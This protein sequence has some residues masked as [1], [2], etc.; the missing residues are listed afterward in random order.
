MNRNN[1][2]IFDQY[3]DDFQFEPYEDDEPSSVKR[4]KDHDLLFHLSTQAMKHNVLINELSKDSSSLDS[5]LVSLNLANA[6]ISRRIQRLEQTVSTGTNCLTC[7]VAS[8]EQADKGFHQLRDEDLKQLENLKNFATFIK[9]FP[10]GFKGAIFAIVVSVI[11]VATATD[12]VIR[13][14][15]IQV[16]KQFLKD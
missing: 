10:F 12:V 5:T 8:L 4:K 9:N 16:I 14:Q 7:R 11:L 1:K 3:D 13:T 15:G 6:E 2:N